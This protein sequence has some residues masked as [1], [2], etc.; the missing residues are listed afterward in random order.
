[1]TSEFAM[2]PQQRVDLLTLAG[3]RLFGA[4]W[5]TLLADALGVQSRTVRRWVA[6]DRVVSPHIIM[7][8]PGVLCRE[9]RERKAAAK[10]IERLASAVEFELEK[11]TEND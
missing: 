5:P 1:M 7:A 3:T 10:E 4:R 2:S 9:A 6:G 8:L 11:V